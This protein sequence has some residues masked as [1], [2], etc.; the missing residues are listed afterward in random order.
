MDA[1]TF[2][3]EHLSELNRAIAFVCRR[4]GIR[5]ADAEDFASRVKLKIIDHDYAVLRKFEARSS[6]Q[7]YMIV[8]I[9]RMLI[10]ERNHEHGKWRP[11]TEAKRLG[12]I[13][14]LLETLL[15]RDGT[16]FEQAAATI[17][18]HTAVSRRH[19]EELAARLPHRHTRPREIS[20]E[21]VPFHA[22]IDG[23]S[24]LHDAQNGERTALAQRIATTLRR[25]VARLSA[26]DRLIFRM[27]FEADMTV[28][29]IARAL[30]IPQKPIYRVL[31]THLKTLRRVLEREG[32]SGLD[33]EDVLGMPATPLDGKLMPLEDAF[34]APAEEE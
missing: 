33:V 27:R 5:G 26:G 16:P 21:D 10:D 28:A 34:V 23:D 30:Q 3:L 13:A 32:I 25:E 6:F 14:I 20:L 11:S 29:E 22:K 4:H 18:S 7:S 9:T 24:V 8:V 17:C 1:E 19:L 12:E 2:F 31:T 15:H